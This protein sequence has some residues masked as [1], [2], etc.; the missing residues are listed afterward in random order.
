MSSDFNLTHKASNRMIS[1]CVFYFPHERGKNPQGR[2]GD[3]QHVAICLIEQ[4]I[5]TCTRQAISLK[6]PQTSTNKRSFNIGTQ[7]VGIARV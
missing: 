4:D 6:S 5:F 7:G 2:E 1:I 3:R